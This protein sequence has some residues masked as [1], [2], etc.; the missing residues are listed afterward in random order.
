MEETQNRLISY[1]YHGY[2]IRV[3]FVITGIIMAATLPIFSSL[4]NLPV[5]ISLIAIVSLAILG[6]FL[7]PIQK[8]IIFIDT[9]VSVI[10]FI[11]FEYYA[12]NTYLHFSPNVSLHIYFYWVNQIMALIF[13]L[14]VYLSIKTLRGKILA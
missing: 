14:A 8:W 3:L 6:G 4:I 12:V 7:N 1:H 10:A 9:I 11:T 13:F 2:R 5:T